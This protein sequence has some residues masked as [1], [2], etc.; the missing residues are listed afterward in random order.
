MKNGNGLLQFA[1]KSEYSCYKGQF[2]EGKR[3]GKGHLRYKDF[4]TYEGEFINNR[5][6]GVGI[7]RSSNGD[8]IYEGN[9]INGQFMK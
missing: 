7:M 4:R 2:K 1:V 9:W 5:L 6:H 8:I 3:E